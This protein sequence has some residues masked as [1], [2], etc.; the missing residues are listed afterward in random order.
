[1]VLKHVFIGCMNKVKHMKSLA[2]QV[3]NVEISVW[4]TPYL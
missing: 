4:A 2:P 3:L 1:M